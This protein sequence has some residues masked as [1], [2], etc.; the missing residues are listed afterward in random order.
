MEYSGDAKI[1]GSGNNLHVVH[2]D[3]QGLYVEFLLESIEDQEESKKL[4]RPFYRDVEMISIRIKGDNKTHIMRKVDMN[5]SAMAPS[6]PDRFP[7]QWAA[8]KNKT[9]VVV[10][11]TPLTEW[12]AISKAQAMNFKTLNIHTV[13]DLAEVSDGNLQNLG[14][15]ARDLRDKAA[16]YIK[17]SSD[18]SAVLRVQE[19]NKEL[20]AKIEYLE[21]QIQLIADKENKKRGKPSKKDLE[22]VE[23]IT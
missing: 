4:G 7:R 1:V 19:E 13:E 20:K 18:G 17:N 14:M 2:G 3:D 6:D 15:G 12:G 10:S 5:G 16:L 11:G 23:D 9:Q 8:F 22:D 21:K